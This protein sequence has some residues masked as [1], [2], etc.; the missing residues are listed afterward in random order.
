M[1]DRDAAHLEYK[2]IRQCI[3]QRFKRGYGLILHVALYLA[4]ALFAVYYAF[5]TIADTETSQWVM[6]KDIAQLFAVW[7]ALLAGHSYLALQRSTAGLRLGWI[8]KDELQQRLEQNQTVL[9]PDPPH[10]AQLQEL[11]LGD[12]RRRAAPRYALM[13]YLLLNLSLGMSWAYGRPVSA[14]DQFHYVWFGAATLAPMIMLPGLSLGF[15]MQRR[16][17]WRVMQVLSNWNALTAQPQPEAP[18]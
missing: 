3:Q 2:E 17:R 14:G 6:N 11:L 15:I 16:Y 9:L 12:I 5:Y 8:I 7:G 10:A 18:R 13:V 1:W 4:V